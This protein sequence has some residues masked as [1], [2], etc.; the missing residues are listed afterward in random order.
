RTRVSNRSGS[1]A[2]GLRSIRSGSI[3]PPFLF[4]RQP[5]AECATSLKEMVSHG[6]FRHPQQL[7]DLAMLPFLQVVQQHD[8]TLMLGQC[9]ER[10]G[11]T[12][13]E[14]SALGITARVLVAGRIRCPLE[15][16]GRAYALLA[17]RT[18]CAVPHDPEQPRAEA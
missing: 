9:L 15:R 14:R 4:R 2:R 10:G 7:T 8:L 11:E 18:E 5:R 16:R 1:S 17:Q 13:S 3:S 12:G 6:A